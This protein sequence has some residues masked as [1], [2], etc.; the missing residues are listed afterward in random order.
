MPRKIVHALDLAAAAAAEKAPQALQTTRVE[1]KP[2]P[3]GG[4]FA[5]FAPDDEPGL[6]YRRSAP[7]P[8]AQPR[9][10]RHFRLRDEMADA[11]DVEPPTAADDAHELSAA[12]PLVRRYEK[13]GGISL[14]NDG[15]WRATFDGPNGVQ[16]DVVACCE[17]CG[18]GRPAT[19]IS[20]P[21]N[22]GIGE[23]YFCKT[24]GEGL[25]D[26]GIP[27]PLQQPTFLCKR[28]PNYGSKPYRSGGAKRIAPPA[29]EIVPPAPEIGPRAPVV[30]TP[31]S[32]FWK[33]CNENRK[34]PEFQ[35]AVKES[36]ETAA[37]EQKER[38]AQISSVVQGT[39]WKVLDLAKTDLP[40]RDGSRAVNVAALLQDFRRQGKAD[41][42]PFSIC[43]A[44][45]AAL[46]K[47]EPLRNEVT[48]HNLVATFAKQVVPKVAVMWKS[49]RRGQSESWHTAV[50]LA[51][52]LAALVGRLTE[53]RRDTT[54]PDEAL[55]RF[56]KATIEAMDEASAYRKRT[57]GTLEDEQLFSGRAGVSAAARV[58]VLNLRARLSHNMQTDI[59]E[60]IP[61]SIE[62]RGHS[63]ASHFELAAS[64]R[65][66]H[67]K[68]KFDAPE[69]VEHLTTRGELA[70]IQCCGEACY[71][72]FDKGISPTG[73]FLRTRPEAGVLDRFY[74]A[75]NFLQ[76]LGDFTG[77]KDSKLGSR[78]S[79][80]FTS[81]TPT[82]TLEPHQIRVIPDIW[83]RGYCWSD[84]CG[85][86]SQELADLVSR[87][88]R[89]AV[90]AVQIRMGLTKGMLVVD[91]SLEGVV[92]CL[93]PSMIKGAS[94]HCCLE[95]KAAAKIKRS[96]NMLF[97]QA[98]IVI[99]Q[100]LT[101]DGDR[102]G[103]D[104][105]F[106][107]K[108][109]NAFIE[110]TLLWT[111][112]DGLPGIRDEGATPAQLA[113]LEAALKAIE[114]L[115]ETFVSE[116]REDDEDDTQLRADLAARRW[117]S[118][119]SSDG[120]P[121]DLKVLNAIKRALVAAKAKM[122]IPCGVNA[123][124]ESDLWIAQG[125]C[126]ADAGIGLAEG[127]VL[128]GNGAYIGEV[129]CFRSPCCNKGDVWKLRAVAGRPE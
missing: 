61:T 102:D 88:M 90:T 82:V 121:E 123:N 111:K 125:V 10:R 39:P 73:H 122:N 75:E 33:E 118:P 99:S 110:D 1:A 105:R 84:G 45:E 8:P 67:T 6:G 104:A 12:A 59:V 112:A 86:M 26:Q 65:F 18:Y 127:E 7:L 41:G 23:P 24:F 74:S 93:R 29:P 15:L 71:F 77:V 60:L 92:V 101:E 46:L 21:F 91:P 4:A 50:A 85:T 38:R 56:S 35:T 43:F 70:P 87:A 9:L 49:R 37:R 25:H 98:I 31:E 103:G 3:R 116:E 34:N 30:E 114:I 115:P 78:C 48:C 19:D 64:D 120:T 119:F 22:S 128:L 62:F 113:A 17:G 54:S 107:H 89:E 106:L 47:N 52:P 129:L 28:C 126:A 117:Q 124:G 51:D 96:G 76:S 44:L 14:G 42:L 13:P 32:S 72:L 58:Q 68:F 66:V 57:I 81:T 83:L 95:V 63:W 20:T 108:L 27:I 53:E 97:C 79:L 100:M 109:M 55:R 16:T 40:R 80:A 94:S 11:R 2:S 5:S 69:I 36:T